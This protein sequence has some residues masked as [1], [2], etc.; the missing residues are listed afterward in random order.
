MHHDG[1]Y[2]VI[3]SRMSGWKPNPNQYASAKQLA[4]PWSEFKDI[5]PPATNTYGSQSTMMLKVVG[6]KQTT[7]IFMG[8]I[9]KPRAQWDSRYLWLPL[10]IGGGNLHLPEP[11]AWTLDVKTGETRMPRP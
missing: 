1:L 6:S 3:G 7:I 4:G 5:A 9:W 2:Y 8:D 10:E 11:R